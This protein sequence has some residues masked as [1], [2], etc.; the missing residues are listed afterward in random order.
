MNKDQGNEPAFPVTH[1]DKLLEAAFATDVDMTN[2]RMNG[3]TLR[4]WVAVTLRVPCSQT[5]WIDAAIR[6]AQRDELARMHYSAHGS[7]M[8]DCYEWADIRLAEK[9][10]GV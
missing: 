4:Q 7:S 1:T 6:E 2:R 10:R 9:E 8:K 5:D 3:M